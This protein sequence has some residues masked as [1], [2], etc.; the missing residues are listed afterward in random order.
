MNK[1]YVKKSIL[2]LGE[3]KA[4]LKNEGYRLIS[5]QS[6]RFRT[7]WNSLLSAMSDLTNWN[8]VVIW[9][10]GNKYWEEAKALCNDYDRGQYSLHEIIDKMK[11][12]GVQ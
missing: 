9:Y 1:P 7:A 11:S 12:A 3:A 4:I 10:A 5:E 8:R 6:D 2:N